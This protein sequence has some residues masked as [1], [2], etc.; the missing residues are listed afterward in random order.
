M[1]QPLSSGFVSVHPSTGCG[2]KEARNYASSHGF[3][4]F[5]GFLF[6]ATVADLVIAHRG[7]QA[8]E[9]LS[10][11]TRVTTN[12]GYVSVVGVGRHTPRR[13][14]TRHGGGRRRGA[15]RNAVRVAK[16]GNRV[17]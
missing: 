10:R 5:R 13:S 6:S 2:I 7:P 4:L 3:D 16:T 15:R 17:C 1:S 14:A 11:A 8:V 9:V 12:G